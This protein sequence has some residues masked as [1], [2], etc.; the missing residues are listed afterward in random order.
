MIE[1]YDKGALQSPKSEHLNHKS[2]KS[3]NPQP[4]ETSRS[5]KLRVPT[6]L[7]SAAAA[8]LPAFL[9]GLGCAGRFSQ[10]FRV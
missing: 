7:S 6:L 1:S 8:P 5:C 4:P 3:L 2:P 10:G 9:R